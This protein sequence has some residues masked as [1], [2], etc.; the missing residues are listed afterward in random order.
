V[1]VAQKIGSASLLTSVRTAFVH[2][3]D[4]ALLV[5]AGFALAGLVLTLLFLPQTNA[6]KAT[7]QAHADKK[8][9]V[10]GTR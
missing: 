9:A 7:T 5:S 10:T 4:M 2:G 1:A 3:M 6:P 8:R